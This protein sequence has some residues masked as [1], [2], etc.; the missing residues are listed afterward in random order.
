MTSE[1]C[2]TL[3]HPSATLLPAEGP[4]WSSG[5]IPLSII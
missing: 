5:E 3:L 1:G 4:G 2:G